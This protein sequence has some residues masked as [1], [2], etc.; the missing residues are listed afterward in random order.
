MIPP[1]VSVLMPCLDP[2]RFLRECLGSVLPQLGP[3][4]ELV[5]QDACSRDGSAEVLDELGTRD[6]RVKVRHERDRGQ[7]DGLNR[8]LVR[9]GNDLVGWLNADDL[10]L[11][12]AL[13]ALRGAWATGGRRLDLAVGGWQVVDGAGH[14]LRTYPART[15][16]RLP[17]LL[18]GCYAFSGAL[19]T[20]RD[21]LVRIGGFAEDLHYTMDLDL[22]L[23]LADAA[24]EQ[25]VVDDPVAALR[26][27]SGSKSGSQAR[28][29]AADGMLVRRR[30][31]RGLAEGATAVAGTA[32]QL[33]SLATHH[34]RFR[35]G[36]SR[37]RERVRS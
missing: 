1:A 5:V 32:I 30:H 29:F 33:A 7:S 35:P 23:R 19:L 14:V 26:L 36:Y 25:A 2:G 18:R 12:G 34:V 37:L 15:L 3:D 13:D 9:A 21:L 17:L 31:S 11:P 24:A 27:H 28:R 4:D 8:A 10:L 16:R 20:R 22:M 6:R